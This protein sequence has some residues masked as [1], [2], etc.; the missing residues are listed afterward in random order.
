MFDLFG[1]ESYVDV[2]L[3]LNNTK[4]SIKWTNYLFLLILSNLFRKQ[5]V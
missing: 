2:N 1:R 5:C 3:Y 4:I